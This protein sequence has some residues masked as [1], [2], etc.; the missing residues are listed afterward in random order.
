MYTVKSG[1]GD[2]W[3]GIKESF[4]RYGSYEI[5]TFNGDSQE[6]KLQAGYTYTLTINASESN[7]DSDGVG[8]EYESW[9]DFSK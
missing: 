6:I 7:P 1:E 8:S 5:M 2:D 4:G 3:F 9:E